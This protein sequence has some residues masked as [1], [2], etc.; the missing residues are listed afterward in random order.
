MNR[1]DV[2]KYI[3]RKCVI[4]LDTGE[5]YKGF[6]KKVTDTSVYI[7]NPMYDKELVLELEKVIAIRVHLSFWERKYNRFF[8]G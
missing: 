3:G 5:E 7:Q 1:A 6:I 4:K 2:E 8:N